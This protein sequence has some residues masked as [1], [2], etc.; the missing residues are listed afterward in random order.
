[1]SVETTHQN[2]EHKNTLIFL[3]TILLQT[4]AEQL[5]IAHANQVFMVQVLGTQCE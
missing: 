3:I 1:M 4:A 5:F 2:K